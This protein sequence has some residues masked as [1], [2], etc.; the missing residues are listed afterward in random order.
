MGY[1]YT[2]PRIDTH[3]NIYIWRNVT[4]MTDR[5]HSEAAV[6]VVAETVERARQ[7]A[8]E[9]GARTDGTNGRMGDAPDGRRMELADDPDFVYPTTENIEQVVV[10]P[11]AGCC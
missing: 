6:L 4:N 8:D 11:D 5:F 7:L 3:M 1:R 2:T 9:F 10:F